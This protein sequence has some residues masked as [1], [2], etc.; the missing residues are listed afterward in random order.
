MVAEDSGPVQKGKRKKKG[1]NL[2]RETDQAV[3][4]IVF[5]WQISPLN[6]ACC[7]EDEQEG[8]GQNENLKK[9][10]DGSKG[11]T[12]EFKGWWLCYQGEQMMGKWT[13]C[14]GGGN[15]KEKTT[16]DQRRGDYEN[17]SFL[18]SKKLAGQ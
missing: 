1:G 5:S 7:R 11:G 12:V 10:E 15:K 17:D 13:K 2:K 8:W 18:I 14:K 4:F 9:K 6:L 3:E 16:R